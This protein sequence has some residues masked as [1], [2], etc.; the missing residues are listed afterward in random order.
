[1]SNDNEFPKDDAF[2]LYATFCGDV[3]RTA[4]AL[5]VDFEEV[6]RRAEAGGWDKKLRGIIE[7]KKSTK[8]GDIERAINRAINFVQAHKLRM[9]L[10][11]ILQRICEVSPDELDEY[12]TTRVT[13]NKGDIVSKVSTRPMADLAVAFEK[14][15]AMT[16]M[17]LGDSA[18]E[19][20]ARESAP[21]SGSTGGELHAKIAAAM[22]RDRTLADAQEQQAKP[23]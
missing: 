19:R 17:A 9:F 14:C 8:P 22:A 20:K 15:Q 5:N 16:Y 4:H 7:L 11:R 21:D 2:M 18:G 3:E 12:M 10:E 13:T 23:K 6:K 1:M